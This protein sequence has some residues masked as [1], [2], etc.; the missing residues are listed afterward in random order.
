MVKAQV[1][2]QAEVDGRLAAEQ[3]QRE[4]DDA[5]A[6]IRERQVVMARLILWVMRYVWPRLTDIEKAEVKAIIPDEMEQDIRAAFEK[7]P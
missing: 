2:T 3:V 1:I 7:L 4:Q 5:L 6:M